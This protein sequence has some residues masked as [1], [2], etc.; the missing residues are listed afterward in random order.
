MRGDILKSIA[1]RQGFRSLPAKFAAR[2]LQAQYHRYLATGHFTAWS[3]D[4]I[5]RRLGK[6]ARG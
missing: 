1:Y 2:V 5:D 6:S 4:N 3:E